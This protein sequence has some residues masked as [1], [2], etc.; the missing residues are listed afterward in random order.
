MRT[1]AHHAGVQRPPPSPHCNLARRCVSNGIFHTRVS[2]LA[3]QT[4][5]LPTKYLAS[6][7]A[8][9]QQQKELIARRARE[10][11]LRTR[12]AIIPEDPPPQAR[13]ILRAFSTQ[14]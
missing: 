7:R 12:S 3:A 10:E 9:I 5:H 4:D 8:L 13:S 14:H 6:M 2:T 11:E 1:V